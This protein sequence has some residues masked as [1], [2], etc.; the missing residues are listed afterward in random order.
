MGHAQ[1][2]RI[3]RTSFPFPRLRPIRALWLAV[4]ALP[5]VAA[6]QP[7]YS[8]ELSGSDLSSN[9]SNFDSTAIGAT[10]YFD[11]VE[12][13]QAPYALAAFFDPATLV[14]A[15][16]S[17]PSKSTDTWTVSGRY[18]LSPSLW[19]VGGQF[20][21]DANGVV[22]V[23][24]DTYGVVAGKYLGPR[25]TL[26]LAMDTSKNELT[27]AF[28]AGCSFPPCPF[29]SLTTRTK[30]E[31]T[32]LSV[33]HVRQFRSLT[34]V[35]T[36]GLRTRETHFT[37]IDNGSVPSLN[38]VGPESPTLRTY[39]V[40]TTL[41]PTKKLG[42]HVGYEDTFGGSFDSYADGTYSV[43]AR[44]F[45]RPKVAFEVSLSRTDFNDPL[46][47]YNETRLRSFRVIGRF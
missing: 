24:T 33:F 43:G 35:L 46:S 14:S 9:L 34:Y 45:F 7:R 13:G 23:D 18:L 17:H 39:S 6:A 4:L 30:T 19:Y 38:L 21:R 32:S 8:W 5:A 31:T 2:L 44:W 27:T 10:Y 26:E 3:G 20:T 47:L 22:D 40:G 37:V 42:V 25:T 16:L 12:D 28:S 1:L 15:T 41:Y 11:R 29:V 36:G